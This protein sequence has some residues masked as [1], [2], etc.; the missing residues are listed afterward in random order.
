MSKA[1]VAGFGS[2]G[3]RHARILSEIGCDVTV[4]SRGAV[5]GYASSRDLATGVSSSAPDYIVVANRTNEHR[6][7]IAVLASGGFSGKVLVEKPLVERSGALPRHGFAGAAVGYNLRCHPLVAK[8]KLLLNDCKRISSAQVYVGSY[9]PDWRP[10]TD[11]LQSYSAKRAEG[12]G[13]L[14]DLSHELDC[15]LW[16]FGPWTRMTALG[17]RF[18]SLEIDSDD[19]YSLLQ[20]TRSCSS[21]T[22]HLN[23]LDRVPRRFIAVNADGKTFHLDL[24]ANTLGVDGARESV[25]VARDDTY[26]AQHKAMLAGDFSNL[27]TFDKGM[28]TV[29]TIEAA[30]RASAGKEWVTR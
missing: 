12:G 1:L 20:E 2:I 13:V 7:S 14:R 18:G 28:E 27:C 8:L 23:Y 24:I 4:V 11:Y 5:D 3:Q 17:G 29:F 30:E 15:A 25:T 22:V 16:M 10:G 26:R 9:L 21:V 6:A 19:S